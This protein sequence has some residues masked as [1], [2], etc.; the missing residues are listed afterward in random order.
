MI[1]YK[2]VEIQHSGIVLESLNVQ[3]PIRVEITIYGHAWTFRFYAETPYGNMWFSNSNRLNTII[4]NLD[5]PEVIAFVRSVSVLSNASRKLYDISDF[6]LR[7][8][9]KEE[10]FTLFGKVA[11][12]LYLSFIQKLYR[13]RESEYY[14]KNKDEMYREHLEALQNLA[15]YSTEANK[16]KSRLENLNVEEMLRYHELKVL[17]KKIGRK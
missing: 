4:S 8:E 3:L 15:N 7:L 12:S 5:S 10:Y 2:M 16:W 11:K 9:E 17:A 1:E 6:A 13:Y 14:D